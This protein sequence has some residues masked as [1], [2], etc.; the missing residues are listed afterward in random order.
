MASTENGRNKSIVYRNCS[1]NLATAHIAID[2]DL[3]PFFTSFMTFS[4]YKSFNQSK[5]GSSESGF[6]GSSRLATFG[7]GPNCSRTR[8]LK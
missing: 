1:H 6:S 7:G 5:C 2:Q 4:V 3:A 8:R